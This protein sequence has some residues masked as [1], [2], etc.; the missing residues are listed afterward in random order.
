MYA[1][2]EFVVGEEEQATASSSFDLARFLRDQ[3]TEL[4]HDEDA[5]DIARRYRERARGDSLASV[6]ANG[7]AGRQAPGFQPDLVGD[8][9]RVDARMDEEFDGLKLMWI[10]PTI[11]SNYFIPAYKKLKH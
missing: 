1:H 11:V 7:R 9:S 10:I 8:T 3:A 2:V 5:D 6:Q 4:E